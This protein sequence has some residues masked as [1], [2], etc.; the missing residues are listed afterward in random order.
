MDSTSAAIISQSSDPKIRILQ[1]PFR[2]GYDA[3]ES[4]T[5][6]SPFSRVHQPQ[7]PS[8]TPSLLE[9]VAD[10]LLK[11]PRDSSSRADFSI[12]ELAQ[13]PIQSIIIEW[14]LYSLLMGRY[15]QLY[16]F[17]L[18]N[19]KKLTSVEISNTMLDLHR[20]RRRSQRSLE[21]LQALRF[22]IKRQVYQSKLTELFAKDVDF[23]LNQI[24]QYRGALES[25]VPILTS[26]IQLIDSRQSMK[27]TTYVKRLTYI[28]LVFLPLSYVAS[29]FSMSEAFAVNTSGFKIYLATAAP[30]LI[31]VL[32]I[33]SLSFCRNPLW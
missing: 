26:I 27:E 5:P 19:L 18:E 12:F 29:L 9:E 25:M 31:L 30:L 8:V 20:W 24:V 21:K 10:A 23:I 17:S 7:P 1:K 15:M 33:S 11:L 13:H 2:G 16:E 3:S 4:S 22:F 6:Y 28:A 32:L 14:T